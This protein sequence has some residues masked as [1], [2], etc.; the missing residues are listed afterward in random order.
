M[1]DELRSFEHFFGLP[2]TPVR[3]SHILPCDLYATIKIP[4]PGRRLNAKCQV[5][6]DNPF[7]DLSWYTG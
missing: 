6:I 4:T 2:R 1:M 3:L 5:I 7:S